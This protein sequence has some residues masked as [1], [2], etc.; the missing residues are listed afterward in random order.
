M[1]VVT[2]LDVSGV[3]RPASG[4]S[5]PPAMRD[6]GAHG[7]PSTPDARRQTPDTAAQ[8]NDASTTLAI[9]PAYNESARIAPVIAGLRQMG[10]PVLVVDDGSRDPTALV[11]QQAGATVLVQANGGKG[12]AL[13]A[14]CRWACDRGYRRVL[15]IDGDGQHDPGEAG[16]L[17]AAAA[18]GGM[19]IG[20]RVRGIGRQPRHR[21]FINRLSSLL[22][23][24]VAGRRIIDSQSGYRVLDPALLLRLPLMGRRYD[25]ETELCVLAARRGER[26]AEVP[27][28]TIYN[29]KRSGV[30]PL[31]DTLRFFRALA[32]SAMRIR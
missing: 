22:V 13:I 27:I 11:A 29:G 26:I 16:Q 8:A 15:L 12:S 23:T 18:R 7:A 2:D 32:G 31:Y 10:L 19:V 24:L 4:V 17:M 28:R 1:N 25:L 30:H 3:R 20:K 21:R 9:I 14:G 5:S 6:D